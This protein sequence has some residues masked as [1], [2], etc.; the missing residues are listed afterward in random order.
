VL[1]YIFGVVLFA[2]KY[3]KL[4]FVVKSQDGLMAGDSGLFSACAEAA[5][6][7]LLR[8]MYCIAQ[9]RAE[10]VGT[11]TLD[12]FQEEA[13]SSLGRHTPCCC[14]GDGQASFSSLCSGR[15]NTNGG[16]KTHVWIPEVGNPWLVRPRSSAPGNWFTTASRKKTVL[17]AMFL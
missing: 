6:C 9:Y 4:F 14:E 15:A 3:Q 2:E 10:A 12:V 8:K 7:Q 5:C 11:V 1:S 17:S 13:K 16:V